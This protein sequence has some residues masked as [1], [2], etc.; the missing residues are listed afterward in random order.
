MRA[1]IEAH[2]CRARTDRYPGD[3]FRLA[4]VAW[5]GTR[6]A[7]GARPGVAPVCG[8]PSA[9]AERPAV[10][11][12]SVPARGR[13]SGRRRDPATRRGRGR[14]R[15]WRRHRRPSPGSVHSRRGRPRPRGTG[16]TRGVPRGPVAAARAR[17]RADGAQRLPW[18][19][20]CGRSTRGARTRCSST[21][22]KTGRQVVRTWRPN[23]GPARS[24]WV[25]Q[26]VGMA[27]ASQTTMWSKS[28]N[29]FRVDIPV[30]PEPKLPASPS[31]SART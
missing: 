14:R 21:P 11:G 30:V 2:G 24:R 1:S 9:P 18:P 13:G 3:G 20:G 31:A 17:W 28:P 12:R 4:A 22:K 23:R 19:R 7:S 26:G 10:S 8:A 16:Q 6:R 15:E 25:G 29:M 27:K 5:A